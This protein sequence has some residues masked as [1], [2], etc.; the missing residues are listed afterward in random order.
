MTDAEFAK[1]NQTAHQ[2]RFRKYGYGKLIPRKI[3]RIIW[4]QQYNSYRLINCGITQVKLTFA[5]T[6]YISLLSVK[7][8]IML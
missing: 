7:T 3:F 5:L 4:M 6:K 2:V 1:Y 8:W